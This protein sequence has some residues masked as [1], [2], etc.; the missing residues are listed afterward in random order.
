[1]IGIILLLQAATYPIVPIQPP[2]FHPPETQVAR[3]LGVDD[4][5]RQQRITL[6]SRWDERDRTT[7]V[8]VREDSSGTLKDGEWLENQSQLY[9]DGDRKHGIALNWDDTSFSKRI[10]NQYVRIVISE[11][12]ISSASILYLVRPYS[13]REETASRHFNKGRIILAGRCTL[14]I[15]DEKRN[16]SNMPEL[17]PVM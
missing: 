15:G 10:G 9:K 7:V 11:T 3:C 4:S 17:G 12:N 6:E 8:F 2:P 5:D 14:F 1:M 16:F 13:D